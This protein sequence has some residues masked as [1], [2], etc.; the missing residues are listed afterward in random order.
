M[1]NSPGWRKE[2]VLCTAGEREDISSANA[3]RNVTN[4][5][6]ARLLQHITSAGSNN[7]RQE[8]QEKA[9]ARTA[10]AHNS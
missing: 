10:T 6:C 8:Q 7:T 1:Q 9:A 3:R 5:L 4:Q 2:A